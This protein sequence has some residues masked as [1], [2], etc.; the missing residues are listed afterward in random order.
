LAHAV[1]QCA[2]TTIGHGVA[3]TWSAHPSDPFPGGYVTQYV[4]NWGDGSAPTT[5]TT[6]SA[7]HTYSA[8]GTFTIK[9]T[10]TDRYG[11]TGTTSNY[12]VKVS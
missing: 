5:T 7:P 4:W 3:G 10:V 6:P 2:D 1:R 9:L 8:A 11:V 12:S